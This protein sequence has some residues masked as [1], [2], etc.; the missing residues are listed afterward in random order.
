VSEQRISRSGDA[1]FYPLMYRRRR[2]RR[3]RR[4]LATTSCRAARPSVRPS[5]KKPHA[6][7]GRAASGGEM[8][9]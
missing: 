6:V 4:L 9:R 5:L 8:D 7:G 3:R 1:G 2:R